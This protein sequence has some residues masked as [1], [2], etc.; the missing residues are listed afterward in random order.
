MTQNNRPVVLSAA[1]VIG[2]RMVDG[3]DT[4]AL[5]L[6]T[7]DDR[8]LAILVPRAAASVLRMALADVLDQPHSD[9]RHEG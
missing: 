9:D 5:Q 2:V 3:G 1:N 8:E 6:E 7:P 4:V